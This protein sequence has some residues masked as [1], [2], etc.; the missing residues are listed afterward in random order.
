MIKICDIEGCEKNAR[1]GSAE[2]CPMHYH[3]IY[4]NG[5]L[6]LKEKSPPYLHKDGYMYQGSA[7][8]HRI[9]YRDHFSDNLPDCWN[10]GME[11]SWDMGKR[12]HIDHIN[13][14]RTD[15]RIENL[16]AS[17]FQCNVR[18]SPHPAEILLTARGRSLNINQWAKEPD[19][20]VCMAT[21][22]RRIK[23][24]GSA[25]AALFG[26]KWRR[27]SRHA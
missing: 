11:L 7:R 27:V 1:S 26:K 21:I 9:I 17:C 25:E 4:R 16:R 2:H 24:G 15:N 10:C 5:S 13:E 3:R 12:M 18:R 22:H 8:Q 14:D 20:K 6:E 23:S 19:I